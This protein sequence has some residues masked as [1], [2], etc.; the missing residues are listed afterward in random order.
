VST[1]ETNPHL[2]IA[3]TGAMACLFGARL[4]QVARVTLTGSW[5]AGL[6][7]I[8]ES[9]IAVDEPPG[10]PPVTVAT[11][12]W[13]AAIAP[14][15][16]V[17]VLVKSWQTAAVGSRLQHLLKPEGVA[18]TLQ[19]GLGNL[20]MLAPRTCLG[21]TYMGATLLG[22]GR[23]RPAGTGPTWISG[24]TW[25]V[26]LFRSA[27]I[28]AESADPQQVDGL[29]W[30]KLA[31]NCGI[32][33]L[34]ALLRVPNGELLRRPD[35]LHLMRRAAMEC[36]E[37]AGAKGIVLPFPDPAERVCE[38]ARL[39]AANYS[40]MLQDVLRGA[41][42]ECAAINGAVADW[43]ARLGV[44]TPVNEALLRLVRSLAATPSGA[45]DEGA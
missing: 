6:A 17:L 38:V 10:R 35:A 8:R 31:V 7:A 2:I 41:P 4:A 37:V 22:P 18:L 34:T 1:V 11:A 20:E 9:G 13:H 29:L 33:A 43:G 24:P 25:I 14:A 30:G 27:G 45:T 36:A 23:V 28:G 16:L 44:A 21:V 12:P 39:T 3:G 32:N 26:R 5:D 40:S 19:N 15:D 42:T